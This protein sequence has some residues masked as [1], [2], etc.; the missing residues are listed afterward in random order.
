[1]ISESC[2]CSFAL[3]MIEGY[4]NLGI[5]EIEIHLEPFMVLSVFVN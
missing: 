1:M 4:A 2:S 5:Q 3:W